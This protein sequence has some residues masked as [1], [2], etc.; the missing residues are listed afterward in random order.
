GSGGG[1]T[2]TLF[3]SASIFNGQ[4]FAVTLA[5]DSNDIYVGGEFTAY[6]G[7]NV[8]RIIRLN[9]DGSIDTDFDI[10][11]GFN[12]RVHSIAT[13]KDGSGDIYVGGKL[14]TYNGTNINHIIRLNSAGSIDTGFDVGTGF[15][16]FVASIAVAT[17]G[18]GD[19]YVGGSFTAYRGIAREFITRINSDGSNDASFDDG[20]GFNGF[21]NSIAVATDSSGDIY[22]G[23]LFT[24]YRGNAR[25]YITRINSDGSNDASFDDGSGFNGFVNSIAVATDGSGD[26][27]VGG[28]F[29]IYRG[30]AREYITRINS[31]GSNDASFDDGTG[32]NTSVS[33]IAVATDGSG[34]IFA[35][36]GF[37]TYRSIARNRLVRIKDD[38]ADDT[39]FGI[40]TGFNS[41]VNSI[42]V[43]TD[44]SGV[45][46]VGGL[47]TSYD[48]TD[49]GYFARLDSLGQLR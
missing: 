8:N 13:A 21:V 11:T 20:S 32:F 49:V 36:G 17:D 1:G 7:T 26:I 12:G 3:S 43:A 24:T 27:Y 41:P 39:N 25:E 19:I 35:G 42:A 48:G 2:S 28:G 9:S 29:S 31:D 6:N 46:F 16:G 37:I 40:G 34:D 4:V 15:N 22:V 33:S 14:T 10:G 30:N 38:G 44:G 23:G 18:S 45:I 5:E 47:F